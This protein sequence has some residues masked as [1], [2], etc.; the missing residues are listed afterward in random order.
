MVV[1]CEARNRKIKNCYHSKPIS[2]VS[3]SNKP[4]RLRQWNDDAMKCALE[5][6][7]EGKMGVNRVALE[8]NVPRTTL[9]DR[10]S[11]RVIHGS[12]MGSNP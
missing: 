1:S 6:V 5:A 10:I 8:S 2:S 4:K 3:T 11:G 7:A 12:N 9:K